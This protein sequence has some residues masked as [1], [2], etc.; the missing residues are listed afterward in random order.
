MSDL[1]RLL[2]V[3]RRT[4]VMPSD[5]VVDVQTSG[6]KASRGEEGHGSSLEHLF[7]DL[8]VRFSMDH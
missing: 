6:G 5:I 3:D 2:D 8:Q 1:A 4:T 7:C